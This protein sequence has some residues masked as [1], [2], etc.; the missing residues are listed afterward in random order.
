ML[1]ATIIAATTTTTKTESIVNQLSGR[2][3]LTIKHQH[4]HHRQRIN[5]NS[6]LFLHN[7]ARF[8]LLACPFISFRFKCYF[9][10]L[11]LLLLLLV[12]S[13]L[14]DHMCV[15]SYDHRRLCAHCRC[16]RRGCSFFPSSSFYSFEMRKNSM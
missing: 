1:A 9:S 3:T 7:P 2:R 13:V 15:Y 11:L 5:H 16:R 10:S 4:H 14:F 12:S 8:G 6:S